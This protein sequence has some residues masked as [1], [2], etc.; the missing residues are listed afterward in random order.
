MPMATKI[1][2]FMDIFDKAGDK[3]ST[4]SLIPLGSSTMASLK[5]LGSGN[6]GTFPPKERKFS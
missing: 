2:T 1:R 4:R 3:N 6:L 5:S